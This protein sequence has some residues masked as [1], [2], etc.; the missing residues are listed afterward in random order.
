[1]TEQ[2]LKAP[3]PHASRTLTDDQIVTVRKLPRRSF[4]SATGV[5]LAGAAAV[6]TGARAMA[7]DPD[8]RPADPDKRPADSDKPDR[9]KDDRDKGDRS[10]TTVIGSRTIGTRSRLILIRGLA[11]RPTR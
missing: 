3:N 8:K 2:N 6:V 4:L 11:T 9:R 7:Q 1:M 5:I 10:E